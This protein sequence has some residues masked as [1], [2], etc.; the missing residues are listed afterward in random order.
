MF[1]NTS[2]PRHGAG[3]LSLVAVGALA[4]TFAGH[5]AAQQPD[6]A[7]ADT[8]VF[9]LEG[10]RIQAQRPVTTVGGASAVEVRVDSLGL[11]PAPT[12]EEVL[13]QLPALHT[14]TNSRG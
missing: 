10:I 3:S 4:L 12:V 9:R 2:R 6:T 14:R 13:R 11:P 8:S 7:Q 1:R 5:V